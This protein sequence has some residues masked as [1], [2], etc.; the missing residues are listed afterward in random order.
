MEIS[1]APVFRSLQKYVGKKMKD[2]VGID[3]ENAPQAP[4]DGV[5]TSNKK[6][7]I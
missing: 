1:D 7:V 3:I 2:E 5:I 4:A 6:N